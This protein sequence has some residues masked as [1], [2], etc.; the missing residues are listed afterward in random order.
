MTDAINYYRGTGQENRIV[1]ETFAIT[2]ETRD[3]KQLFCELE[4]TLSTSW[5]AMY[6]IAK[7]YY[8]KHRTLSVSNRYVTEDGYGLGSWLSTRS[9]VK[10]RQN[11]RNS[12]RRQNNET[13]RHRHG[14][15]EQI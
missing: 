13:R 5:D 4:E 11:T 2:D 14:M 10:N 12:H 3:S 9:R 1:N 15:A 8:I 6:Q 7:E